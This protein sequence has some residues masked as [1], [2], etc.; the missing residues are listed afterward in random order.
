MVVD[1]DITVGFASATSA[2]SADG[3]MDSPTTPGNGDMEWCLSLT[4]ICLS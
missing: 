4:D 3:N 1:L 2:T